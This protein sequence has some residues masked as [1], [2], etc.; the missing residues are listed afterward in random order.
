MQSS[1]A[2][3]GDVSAQEVLLS[4]SGYPIGTLVGVTCPGSQHA[5][6]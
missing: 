5:L 1:L 4:K 6:S 2:C 3:C